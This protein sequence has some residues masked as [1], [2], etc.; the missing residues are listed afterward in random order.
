[1]YRGPPTQVPIP[2]TGHSAACTRYLYSIAGAAASVCKP[3]GRVISPPWLHLGED[4]GVDVEWGDRL[5]SKRKKTHARLDVCGVETCT[6][7]GGA[8][9]FGC[10]PG[11]MFQCLGGGVEVRSMLLISESGKQV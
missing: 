5:S 9:L 11:S 8:C 1:M 3:R 4:G 10:G 7:V 2:T 6:C